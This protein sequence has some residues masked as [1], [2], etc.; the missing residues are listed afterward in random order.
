[1]TWSQLCTH[2]CPTYM[3]QAASSCLSLKII[4]LWES[5]PHLSRNQNHVNKNGIYD[6]GS[7]GM[8]AYPVDPVQLQIYPPP[9]SVPPA[10]TQRCVLL[11]ASQGYRDQTWLN[12]DLLL[13]AMKATN[14]LLWL[15]IIRI[16]RKQNVGSRIWNSSAASCH[17][18]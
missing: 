10:S 18:V 6:V 9:S 8:A 4:K 12:D 7:N 16:W 1:M 17:A 13:H 5:Y 14:T 11:L 2:F 15:V 3:T